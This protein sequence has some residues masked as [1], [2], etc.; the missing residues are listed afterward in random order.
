MPP[1][2]KWLGPIGAREI[3][4]RELRSRMPKLDLVDFTPG[5]KCPIF[6]PRAS[7]GKLTEKPH[8]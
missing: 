3:T 4:V 1:Q 7:E 5:S 8:F 2:G 6:P